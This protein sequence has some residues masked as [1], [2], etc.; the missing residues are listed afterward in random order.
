[1]DWVA[2]SIRRRW[3]GDGPN[4]FGDFFVI[5]V[6]RSRLITPG[7]L[8]WK[9]DYTKTD[10]SGVQI[11]SARLPAEPK[12]AGDL[13]DEG[14]VD[15]EDLSELAKQWLW[16]GPEGGVPEDIVEDGAVNLADFAEL[17]ENWMWT[18]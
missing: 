3:I 16:T 4:S 13:T 18:E 6:D 11:I 7:S 2:A 14:K 12:I 17:A 10:G 15:F 8:T 9:L 5:A 1:M